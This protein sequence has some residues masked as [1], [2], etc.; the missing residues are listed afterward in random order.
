MCVGQAGSRQAAVHMQSDCGNQR[1]L[2][3]GGGLGAGPWE[4]NKISIG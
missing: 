1:S 2:P 3:S 4:M